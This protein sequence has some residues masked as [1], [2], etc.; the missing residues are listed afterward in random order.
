MAKATK[1]AV[2]QKKVVLPVIEHGADLITISEY[3]RRKNELLQKDNPLA[4]I[5]Y[6]HSIYRNINDGHMETVTFGRNRF[7]DWNKYQHFVFRT[8]K[9]DARS[10]GLV[11]IK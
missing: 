7:I 8:C 6:P 3:V 4:P 10:K 11:G 1:K 2:K 9:T 5:I